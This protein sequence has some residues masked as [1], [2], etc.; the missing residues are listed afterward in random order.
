MKA[1][2]VGLAAA[3]ATAGSAEAAGS[4]TFKDWTAV[5]DNLRAC[6]AFGFSKDTDHDIVYLKVARGGAG[7]DRPIVSLAHL[8]DAVTSKGAW[9]LAVDG[10]PL[11]GVA[12]GRPKAG[13]TYETV[14]LSAAQSDSL[15]RA[16]RNGSSL[17]I[18]DGG[19]AVGSISLS[20]VVAALLWLDEQQKRVG[21]VTAL[22]RPGPQPATA[23][24]PVP[25]APSVAAGPA[26]SQAGVPE[27]IP[28]A[29]RARLEGND[30]CVSP[31]TSDEEAVIVRLAPGLMLWGP[32][33]DRAAYNVIHAFFLGDEAGGALRPVSFPLPPESSE[34]TIGEIMNVDFDPATRTLTSFSKGR[35][36]GDCGDETSWVWD[37]R[38]FQLLRQ[39][40]MPECNGVTSED[41]PAIYVARRR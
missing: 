16:V 2:W 14:T 23:V 8:A 4:R 11:A 32:V 21:T 20:G 3:L 5:C 18:S 28:A 12:P 29:V 1:F 19:Q 41:W 33:C 9:S 35:G 25:A 24:P 39:T 37:G 26:A 30:V 34:P 13:E 27:R 17:S 6:S 10:R 15:L 40:V 38:A 7:A 31:P 36:L 22:A